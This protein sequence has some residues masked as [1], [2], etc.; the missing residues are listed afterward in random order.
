MERREFLNHAL[1]AGATALGAGLIPAAAAAARSALKCHPPR[2][3]IIFHGLFGFAVPP[4]GPI[5]AMVPSVPNHDLKMGP[6]GLETDLV[7]LPGPFTVGSDTDVAATD[8]RTTVYVTKVHGLSPHTQARMTLEFPR[9]RFVGL[10]LAPRGHAFCGAAA[11][12]LATKEIPLILVL[13]YPLLTGQT[14][15]FG[16]LTLPFTQSLPPGVSP[17]NLHIWSDPGSAVPMGSKPHF[18]DAVKLFDRL[19][20]SLCHS[21]SSP[22]IPPSG[23][24]CGVAKFEQ[25]PACPPHRGGMYPYTTQLISCASLIVNTP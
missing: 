18:N 12:T 22:C 19:D 3:N 15:T 9:A 16:G 2:I 21:P 14:V 5:R 10:R 1:G 17:Y 13:S 20:L 7:Q 6:W 25:G 23:H 11:Q 4:R 24:V 8:P